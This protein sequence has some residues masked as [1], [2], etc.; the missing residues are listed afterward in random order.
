MS[1]GIET[2]TTYG[3]YDWFGFKQA[4]YQVTTSLDV[5]GGYNTGEDTYHDYIDT[6]YPVAYLSLVTRGCRDYNGDL[7]CTAACADPARVF[8]NSATLAK[9]PDSSYNSMTKKLTFTNAA[10]EFARAYGIEA[11]PDLD[12]DTAAPWAVINNCTTT[13][14]KAV[15]PA[16]TNCSATDS[17]GFRANWHIGDWRPAL[18][19][20]TT[21]CDNI[22]ASINQDLGGV[23]MIIAYLLQISLLLAGWVLESINSAGTAVYVWGSTLFRPPHE[24]RVRRHRAKRIQHRVLISRQAVALKAALVEFQRTQTF[25]VLAVAVAALLAVNNAAYL[26]VSS[27]QQ[28]WNNIGFM[29]TVAL[30]GCY[31][32]V[33]NLLIL[34]KSASEASPVYLLAISTGC[35]AISTTL[36]ISTVLHQPSE[37][38]ITF[39]NGYYLP[40][41]GTEELT[42][43][44]WTCLQV[45]G[46]YIAGI[47]AKGTVLIF[48]LVV[49]VF[50]LA[51]AIKLFRTAG[52]HG[53]GEKVNIFEYLRTL[54]K[55]DRAPAYRNIGSGFTVASTWSWNRIPGKTKHA[56]N[57][58]KQ[59]LR[60]WHRSATWKRQDLTSSAYFRHPRLADLAATA[61]DKVFTPGADALSKTWTGTRRSWRG[62]NVPLA[63]LEVSY[64]VVPVLAEL[65]LVSIN[66]VLLAQY[67]RYLG[68]LT[69][70]AWSLGQVI[71]VTIWVPVVVEYAYLLICGIEEGFEYRLTSPYHVKKVDDAESDDDE[72]AGADPIGRASSHDT[73]RPLGIPEDSRRKSSLAK[74]P[75]S[76]AME[77][78][79]PVRPGGSRAESD[80]AL[81]SSLRSR[82]SVSPFE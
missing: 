19:V 48:P 74:E 28:L 31:P 81:L 55:L 16:D 2:S 40:E 47:S 73:A 79:G 60:S 17:M 6:S 61:S 49:L 54:M 42:N 3:Y 34:R 23:G 41:C 30:S 5:S 38:Q 20:N 35:V 69:G 53:R 14:C 29:S 56:I 68:V 37:D 22:N 13:Y 21:L 66:A 25:F 1:L 82:E 10:P 63:I 45:G 27:Y 71:S 9:L 52:S 7:N 11:A 51:E 58:S 26:Q 18:H 78:D 32:V 4:V 64:A 62:W 43:P 77:M 72:N 36:W 80:A 65:G 24:K 44:T 76:D 70:A 57:D 75:F 67:A 39:S 59:T 15:S 33:L 8:N 46:D 12:I 50:L